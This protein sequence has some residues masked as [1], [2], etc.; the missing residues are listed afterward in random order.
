MRGGGK[1]KMIKIEKAVIN[2]GVGDAGEKLI[3][4]EKVLGILTKKKPVRT[5]SKTTNRDFGIRKDMPIGCK[6]TLRGKEAEEFIKRAF[7]VKE[8]GSQSIRS[9]RKVTS[10]LESLTIPTLKA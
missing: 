9:T 10:P 5:V 1:M 6:V 7:W 3:K 2:I 4:A 8:T